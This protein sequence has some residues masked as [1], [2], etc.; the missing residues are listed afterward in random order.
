MIKGTHIPYIELTELYTN[1]V[2]HLK[3]T[4]IL[5]IL[6]NNEIYA[7]IYGDKAEYVKGTEVTINHAR[8]FVRESPGRIRQLIRNA[9][10]GDL[11]MGD[12]K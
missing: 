2:L 3:A 11:P 4:N 9:T 10:K 1:N 8:F 7:G 5:S 6:L 12:F